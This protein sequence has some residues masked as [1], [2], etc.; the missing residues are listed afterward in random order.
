M[1]RFTRRATPVD[2]FERN[3]RPPMPRFSLI[4]DN[5]IIG[6]VGHGLGNHALAALRCQ[7]C[8]I[9]HVCGLAGGLNGHAAI[10]VPSNAAAIGRA[11][12]ATSN[13]LFGAAITLA[14][15]KKAVDLDDACVD[16]CLPC[17]E[18]HIG[19]H[20]L[21]AVCPRINATMT[22]VFPQRQNQRHDA[23]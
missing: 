2:D 12:E 1:Y 4:G 22:E 3:S 17:L 16:P 6:Y 9:A 15:I 11:L 8:E 23:S 13:G 10:T 20:G 18:F 7:R 19:N 14:F 5:E 21:T